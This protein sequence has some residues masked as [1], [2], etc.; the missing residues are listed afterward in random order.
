MARKS[1]RTDAAS[2]GAP[3]APKPEACR[4]GVYARTSKLLDDDGAT[5]DN[6]RRIVEEHLAKM[7]DAVVAQVY[8]DEGHTGTNQD[9]EAFQRMVDDLRAGRIGGVAAKDASRLGRDYIECQQF[10]KET[11]PSVG[12]RL[13]LVS[14]GLDSKDDAS[15]QGVALDLR[16]LLN[17]LYSRDLS[18]KIHGTFAA[19]RRRGPMILGGIPY[20]YMRDPEDAHHLVPDPQ[21]AC[22]VREMFRMS[23]RGLSNAKIADYLNDAGAPTAGRVKYARAGME[24]TSRDS[25][26]W[27][28][29]NV[30]RMLANPVYKGTLVMSRWSQ[31]LYMKKPHAKND[32]GEWVVVEGAHEPLVSLADFD[33][34]QREREERLEKRRASLAATARMREALPDRLPG[35]VRCGVC[36]ASMHLCRWMQDGVLWG[37]E[38]CC[39]NKDRGKGGG[40]HRVAAGLVETLSM[41][42]IRSQLAIASETDALL[43]DLRGPGGAAALVAGIDDGLLE[44]DAR[45][46]RVRRAAGPAGAFSAELADAA[47]EGITVNADGSLDFALK[48]EDAR[49][50]RAK[51][52]EALR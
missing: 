33:R 23:A 30:N 12:A 4:F 50:R 20:G 37:A 29:R 1:R 40:R 3:E 52:E 32:P 19:A 22:H 7:P 27:R 46:E 26:R 25:G 8:A 39:S 49:A 51:I 17:D 21:V 28:A 24:P 2:Q 35:K 47:I 44:P 31:K 41:D 42:V 10:I 16:S 18:R 13:V 36:G 38:Y 11:L 6:Q 5:I 9:R 34:L 45:L 43:A 14:E 15:L 48:F